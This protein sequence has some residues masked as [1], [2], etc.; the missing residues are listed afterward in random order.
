MVKTI[1]VPQT[2]KDALNIYDINKLLTRAISEDYKIPLATWE[3]YKRSAKFDTSVEIDLS[4]DALKILD[5]YCTN[6]NSSSVKHTEILAFLVDM[7]CDCSKINSKDIDTVLDIFYTADSKDQTAILRAYSQSLYG[8]DTL[9]MGDV[10]YF[11]LSQDG[12]EL[13]KELNLNK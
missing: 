7:A 1:N 11:L 13:L 2:V 5:N 6:M 3:V 8:Q 9:D 10:A 12:Q 4:E